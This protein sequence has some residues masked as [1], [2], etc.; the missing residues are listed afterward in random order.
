MTE[1]AKP[2]VKP[3]VARLL[4]I[5]GATRSIEKRG[6][7]AH[8]KYKFYKESDVAEAIRDLFV[9]HGVFCL[10]SMEDVTQVRDN[11]TR[12]RMRYT[13][14]NADDP[15]DVYSVSFFGDGCDNQDKGIYK[16][17]TGCQK[18][19][20]L[21]T[22]QLGSDEDPENERE[23]KPSQRHSAPA[24][25]AYQGKNGAAVPHDEAPPFDD[26]PDYEDESQAPAP[27]VAYRVP[28]QE[29]EA[30]K[31]QLKDH[32]HRWNPEMKAWTGG[33]EVGGQIEQYRV[34]A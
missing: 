16:A 4:S 22:F 11:H 21:K 1:K 19:M 13:F 18:Y 32:G 9:E 15:E 6:Y 26:M 5:C 10:P 30:W 17:L 23:A 29:R 33:S 7:N 28:Y 12:I 27:P 20:L 25:P 34:R 14:I 2:A 24:R 3:L 31:G 8:F